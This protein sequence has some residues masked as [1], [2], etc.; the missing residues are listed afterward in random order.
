MVHQESGPRK[1]SK[2]RGRPFPKGNKRGKLE[3]DLLVTE[4]HQISDGGEIINQESSA[5]LKLPAK[6][7]EMMQSVIDA[8]KIETSSKEIELVESIDFM[9]GENKLS[10]RY[11]R[12]QNR[13]FRLQIF[14]NDE[15]EIRPVT[16]QGSSTSYSFWNLLKGSLK[17]SKQE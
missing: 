7:V 6:A 13:S 11:S 3:G 8:P 4:R 1:T 17:K 12:K 2:P 14:L 16:Y 15:L 5:E 10:L 9:H